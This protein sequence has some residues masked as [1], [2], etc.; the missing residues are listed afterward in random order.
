MDDK[1]N[2]EIVQGYEIKRAITFENNRGFAL[3]ENPNAPEPFVTWQFKENEKGERDYY[4]G[5][6]FSNNETA[7]RNYELR[8]DS[9]HK[10][11]EIFD[12]DGYVYY[13]TQ[14]PVDIGTFPKTD[15]GPVIIF[16][17]DKRDDIV[18][19]NFKAWGYLIYDAP[20]TE[21][22][23]K[24]YE[25][26]AARDNPDVVAVMREQA[27]TVG[28]WEK[29]KN[30]P[31]DERFTWYRKATNTFEMCLPRV[32]PEQIAERYQFAKQELTYAAEKANAPKPIM[33]QFADAEKQV[34][35]G[36]T[37]PVDKKILREDRE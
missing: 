4:W 36:E 33:E 8:A 23:I 37:T 21:K 14:R 13:S 1:N 10:N 30:L 35:R 12:L 28:S 5:Q 20:L 15:N 11:N 19:E 25:L 16:N 18:K 7:T 32:S 27:Q 9:Y 29:M 17:F 34:Q 22:Q 6:Y 2:K 24:D 3:A 31:D 26:R